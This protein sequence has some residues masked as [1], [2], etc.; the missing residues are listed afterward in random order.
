MGV[1]VY[2]Y[3]PSVALKDLARYGW[4]EAD[5][6]FASTKCMEL[7]STSDLKSDLKSD[8]VLEILSNTIVSIEVKVLMMLWMATFRCDDDHGDDERCGTI[9]LLFFN[10]YFINYYY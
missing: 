1:Y 6:H 4:T 2:I 8:Q 7:E 3:M 9:L 5:V 10:F